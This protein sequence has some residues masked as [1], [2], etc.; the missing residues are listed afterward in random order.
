MFE[1]QEGIV[2]LWCPGAL[3]PPYP[4]SAVVECFSFDAG[5]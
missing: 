2:P 5:E 3:Q 1:K 4:H